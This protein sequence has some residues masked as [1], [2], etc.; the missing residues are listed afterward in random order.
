MKL[1]I[2]KQ[3]LGFQ[4]YFCDTRGKF[5][6]WVT[7]AGFALVWHPTFNRIF[8]LNN[9]WNNSGYEEALK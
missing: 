7:N 2:S 9:S 4:Q 8:F 5:N 3:D 1:L 6:C